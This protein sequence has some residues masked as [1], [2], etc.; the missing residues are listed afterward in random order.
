[1]SRKKLPK[2]QDKI[3]I[4]ITIDRKIN[5]GIEKLTY[6]KSKYIEELLMKHLEEYGK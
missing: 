1:M 5:S 2:G 3:K 4:S 6:N